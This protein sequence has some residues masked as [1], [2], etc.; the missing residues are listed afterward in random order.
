MKISI[1]TNGKIESIPW[2]KKK[3]REVSREAHFVICADGASK[4]LTEIDFVPDLLMGDLDS[5][6]EEAKRWMEE[7]DVAVKKFPAKKD[8]TD[9]EIALDY[10]LA[11]K[12]ESIEILGAFGSRMDHTLANVQLLEGYYDPDISIKLMD[13]QNE[14]WLLEK[15]TKIT[16][17]ENENLSL[18]PISES[19]TGVTLK[20]FEYPLRDQKLLRGHT[21]GISNIIK[22]QQAEIFF[23]EGRLLAVIARD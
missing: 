23:R 13:G 18:I 16:G 7:R 1:V 19:V 20:G 11:M 22:D 10:S 4:Y 5:I 8:Q 12:P 9:T 17:R 6:D 15:Y 14:L 2:L 21:L 3:L